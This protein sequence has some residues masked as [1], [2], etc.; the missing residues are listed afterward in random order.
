MR[1]IP[2]VL[3]DYPVETILRDLSLALRHP[4]ETHAAL[5]LRFHEIY[6]DRSVVFV[7]SGTSALGIAIKTARGERDLPVA[8]PAYACP[9]VGTALQIAG[10]Q[11]LVYDT[12]PSTLSP[13]L[14]SLERC[15]NA[16]CNVIV[17]VHLFGIP[18]DFRS[19]RELADRF[20]ALIVE[21]AAQHAGASWEGTRLGGLGDFGV[22]SFGRGKGLNAMGGGA[23][24]HAAATQAGSE[25]SINPSTAAPRLRTGAAALALRLSAHP[26]VYGAIS[27][28]PSLHVG[29]TMYRAPH[30]AGAMNAM[31]SAL[32]LT[33]LALEVEQ[34][35][36][37]LQNA[38]TWLEQLRD[39]RGFER[40]AVHSMASPSFLRLPLR[41]SVPPTA[42][43]GRYG[44][45]RSYPRTLLDYPELTGVV[46]GT[47][48]SYPGAEELATRLW[49]FPTHAGVTLR[50]Q[51]SA[52]KLLAALKRDGT[53]VG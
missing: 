17:V 8:V 36:G 50:D 18:V 19:V 25:Q 3:S 51:A 5:V 12:D 4:E 14:Q 41:L 15:L 31:S 32:L 11:G 30:A 24:L 13:D 27:R 7:D 26:Q 45:V 39:V 40:I 2:P 38:S 42:A 49:T 16:G 28:L 33:A 23:V 6:P 52:V 9:D 29:Q 21:D 46:W 22:L 48:P 43:I 53:T 37:R 10:A 47:E 34:I 1:S 20:G 44:I 35:R